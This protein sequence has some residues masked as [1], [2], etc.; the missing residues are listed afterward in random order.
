MRGKVLG[1]LTLIALS[2]LVGTSIGS[3]DARPFLFVLAGQ[4]IFWLGYLFAR[5]DADEE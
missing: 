3:G 5:M 2:V 4:V 1:V